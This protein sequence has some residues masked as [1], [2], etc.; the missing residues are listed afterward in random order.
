MLTC[1]HACWVR[2]SAVYRSLTDIWC[3]C[4]WVQ[5]CVEKYNRATIIAIGQHAI[6]FHMPL[7]KDRGCFLPESAAYDFVLMVNGPHSASGPVNMPMF[8][9]C[10]CT[11]TNMGGMIR[12]SIVRKMKKKVGK[13]K[14]LKVNLPVQQDM[15][16]IRRPNDPAP[17]TPA[18]A[19]QQRSG[20]LLLCTFLCVASC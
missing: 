3:C 2:A 18:Q 16:L 8:Q 6:R 7:L 14:W 12:V 15:I 19:A 13:K 11:I 4:V 1:S 20:T 9:S 17:P 10:W 5:C